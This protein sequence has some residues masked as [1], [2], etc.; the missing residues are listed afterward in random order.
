MHFV[1]TPSDMDFVSKSSLLN[2]F[3]F[4]YGLL[5]LELYLRT[6][7][8]RPSFLTVGFLYSLYVEQK[9]KDDDPE[10]WSRSTSMLQ[11]ATSIFC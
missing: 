7:I 2:S 5:S 9:E 4:L 10:Y 8:N 3:L 6:L 1:R 11:I